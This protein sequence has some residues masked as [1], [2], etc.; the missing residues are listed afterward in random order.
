[1]G[2]VSDA[3]SAPVAEHEGVDLTIT[4]DEC[5]PPRGALRGPE[6]EEVPFHGRMSLLQ[7]ID[8]VLASGASVAVVVAAGEQAG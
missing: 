2:Q 4:F 7:A 1:M 3:L 8:R 6:G 5:E